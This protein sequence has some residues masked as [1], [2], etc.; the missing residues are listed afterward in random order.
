MM[1]IFSFRSDINSRM[2]VAT[3]VP[4]EDCKSMVHLSVKLMVSLL[5]SLSVNATGY[6]LV[7]LSVT[8]MVVLLVP[9][10]VI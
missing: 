6:L 5:A 7:L 3:H 4:G 9:S 1:S 8:S 2:V 10:L